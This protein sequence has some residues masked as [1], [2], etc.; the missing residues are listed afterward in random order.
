MLAAL[1]LR[2]LECCI[3]SGRVELSAPEP[4]ECHLGPLRIPGGDGAPSTRVAPKP[5]AL[6]V[7][8][9]LDETL[10][11]CLSRL[12]RWERATRGRR[13]G[14]FCALLP[15]GVFLCRCAHSHSLK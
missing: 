5:P 4:Q 3:R 8:I 15:K 10:A 9:C 2:C 14:V 7:P 13:P 11:G 12:Y 1:H 6:K